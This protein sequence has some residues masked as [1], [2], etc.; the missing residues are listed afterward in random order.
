MHFGDPVVEA[1]ANQSAHNRVVGVECVAA[2]AVVGIGGRLAAGDVVGHILE[3]TI[4]EGGA[5]GAILGRV[6][7]DHVEEDGD[8]GAMQRLDHVTEL[9]HHGQRIAVH[10]ILAVRR[11]EG[12]RAVAPVVGQPCGRILRIELRHGQQFHG[13]DAKRL[14]VRNLFNESAIGA[15]QFIAHA[16]IGVPCEARDVHLVDHRA[17]MSPGWGRVILPVVGGGVHDHRAQRL[18]HVVALAAGCGAVVDARRNRS[19]VGVDQ[20]LLAIEAVAMNGVIGAV[21]AE[22]VE[23][24]RAQTRHAHVPVVEGAIDSRVQADGAC[25][26]GVER[27]I[28]KKQFDRGRMLREDRKIDTQ[29]RDCSA[30][31]VALTRKRFS[32]HKGSN[33]CNERRG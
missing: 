31:R 19:S 1:V 28:E 24:P 16:R 11:H 18:G 21:Y 20:H 15:A 17:L 13:V 9:V 33:E 3:A 27:A 4:T 5:V 30:N 29:G 14:Q 23:L 7:E 32:R 25:W 26:R 10:G 22:G 2:A 6:V 12:N 8:A